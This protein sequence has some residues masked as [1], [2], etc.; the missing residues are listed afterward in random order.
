MEENTD[1]VFFETAFEIQR[2][3]LAVEACDDDTR[4]V[5][6]A[7]AEVVDEPQRVVVV[8]DAEIRADFLAFDVARM[9]ADDDVR[10]GGKILQKAHFDVWIETGQDARG[11]EARRIPS[12]NHER[13][14][15]E[16]SPTSPHCPWQI[17]YLIEILPKLQIFSS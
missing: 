11:M 8:G 5:D 7:V 15:H 1:A 12:K 10:I 4:D 17:P 9:D 16:P 3:G 2:G 14:F 6:V 13:H